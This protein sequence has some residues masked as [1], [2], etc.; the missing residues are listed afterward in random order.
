[1]SVT[2]PLCR[3]YSVAAGRPDSLQCA[4][5]RRVVAGWVAN[6]GDGGDES[7]GVPGPQD[8]L[9]RRWRTKAVAGVSDATE[10]L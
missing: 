5:F 10:A 2:H 3:Y 4:T 9:D 1:M 6:P 7:F 8:T